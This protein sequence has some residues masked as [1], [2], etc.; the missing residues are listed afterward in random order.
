MT[1]GLLSKA[2]QENYLY[3]EGPDDKNVFLHLLNHH[4][5]TTPNLAQRGY[6][7]GK[8]EHFEIKDCSGIENLLEVFHVALKG[9][10]DN[11]RLH[12]WLA[13]QE[14]PGTPMGQAITKR[15]VDASSPHALP[16]ISW[17][18]RVFGLELPEI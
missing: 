6:F 4:G 9:D 3:V 18:R 2:K 17:F 11:K 14:E 10:A 12:T 15:Y 7:K 16:L 8:N 5:I 13:W 1:S